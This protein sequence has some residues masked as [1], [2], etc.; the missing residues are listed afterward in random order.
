M[1]IIGAK[2]FAK[3]VLEI[4]YHQ[5][6]KEEIFFFDDVSTDLPERLF[7]QFPIIRDLKALEKHF[8]EVDN[9]FALGLGNPRL[10]RML[11]QK[12]T[13]IGGSPVST[14]ARSVEIG[15]FDNSIGAGVN[16]MSGTKITNSITIGEGCLVNL[17]CTVGHDTIIGAFTEMSPGG[18]VSGRVTI[19]SDVT[20]GTNAIIL[21]QIT[22][23]DGAVIG[24]GAVVTKDIPGNSLAVG[25]PA[26]VVKS[27]S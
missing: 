4:V 6:P 17:N 19:G 11:Y 16:I 23:G 1:V 18:N 12:M 3:E 20:I 25:V 21:P 15:S 26:V 10:R 2:G 13:A 27:L 8:L 5:Y 22:I 14:I 9:R 7:E 24:A